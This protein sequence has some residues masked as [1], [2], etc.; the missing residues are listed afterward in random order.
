MPDLILRPIQMH[1]MPRMLL[2]IV[3]LCLSASS[4]VFAQ[5]AED[6]AGRVTL[7]FQDSPAVTPVAA[8]VELAS[9]TEAAPPQIWARGEYLLWWTKNA[10]LPLP[11]VTTGDP[12]VGF[13]ALNTA[14]AIGQPGTRVLLGNAGQD[15]GAFSGMRFT[16]GGWL[17]RDQMLGVEASG[18][19]LENRL[20][21]FAA[22]SDANGNPPLYFPRFN[23]FTG[24]EGGVPIAD[25]LRGFAGSVA[26]TS[27]LQLWGAEGNGCLA[28]WRS[29]GLEL[30][31]L[32]GFRYADLKE[33]L[34]INNTTTDLIF[35]NTT[36]L[37]DSFGTRNQFYGGQIGARLDLERGRFSLDMTG[38]LA[39]GSTHEV[40]NIQG[41]I[42]QLGP[43]PLVPPGF[44]TFPGGLFA[45]PSNIGRYTGNQFSVLPA[46]E[47]K[48]AYRITERLRAFVGYDFMYLSQVVRPGNQ[49]NHSVNLTQNAVLDPA[50]VGAL[51]GPAQPA[52]LFQR[53]DF[54]AQGVTFGLEF[55]Y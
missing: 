41:A 6:A 5:A 49:I 47:L 42:T 20:D 54:W 16:L 38:K 45:Q 27:A 51:V 33:S 50:G 21:H 25:P 30:C 48:L 23:A 12:N 9:W 53:S 32:M 37:T 10:P 2:G 40:V 24:A 15:F 43:N 14:G 1:G 26:V 13:P 4:P 29:P 44:G 11:L 22:A 55:R 39:M 52:P 17:G 34:N 46:V 31:L 3:I 8:Y 28:L 35:L 18:F 7:G 36:T 19:L